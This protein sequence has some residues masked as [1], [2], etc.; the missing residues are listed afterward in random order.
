MSHVEIGLI[1]KRCLS[2][3]FIFFSE[4]ISFIDTPTLQNAEEHKEAVVHCRAKG[5]PQP[6][7]NWYFNGQQIDG[8]FSFFYKPFQVTTV[9][10]PANETT[11]VGSVKRLQLPFIKPLSRIKM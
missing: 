7:I 11:V 8:K 10:R 6:K 4:P 5:N 9:V 2:V 1:K 3:L